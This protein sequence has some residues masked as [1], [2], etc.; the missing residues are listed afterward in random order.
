MKSSK[1]TI[2]IMKILLLLVIFILPHSVIK[3]QIIDKRTGIKVYFEVGDDT[4]PES[5]KTK[6]INAKAVDLVSDEK[7]R[8]IKVLR[9]A[10]AKYPKDVLSKNIK[11]IYVLK[12]IEFFGLIY[13]GTCS[14][15]AVYIANN[16]VS[17]GYTDHY[18][19]QTFHHEFSSILLRN[20]SQYFQKKLWLSVNKM[21]YGDGGIEAL[22]SSKDD[23]DYDSRYNSK[24]FLYQ[25]ASSDQENDFNSFAE[26]IFAPDEEF[27]KIVNKY[28]GLKM[29][30]KLIIQFYHRLNPVFTKEYFER[31]VK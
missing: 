5:W 20:Y 26:N 14:N 16:G 10:L 28:E 12:S 31:Y 1:N 11:K 30:L 3:A 24:G 23:I 8:S 13:G 2:C 29:K 25:Y 6:E 15:D 9:V 21:E 17:M 4:F 7:L 27:Y 18:L 22:R 19:E